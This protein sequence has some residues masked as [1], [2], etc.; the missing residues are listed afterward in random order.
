MFTGIIEEKARI[1]KITQGAVWRIAITSHLETKQ[2]IVWQFRV[3]VL[4]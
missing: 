1:H 4:R 2:E 3:S